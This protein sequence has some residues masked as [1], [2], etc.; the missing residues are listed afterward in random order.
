MLARA[1][2]PR[3]GELRAVLG[4][5]AGHGVGVARY[6]AHAWSRLRRRGGDALDIIRG[7]EHVRV[8]RAR[9]RSRRAIDR[10]LDEDPSRPGAAP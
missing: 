10:W 3:A 9:E 2:V 5:P 8:A 4:L 6:V 1:L 7:A